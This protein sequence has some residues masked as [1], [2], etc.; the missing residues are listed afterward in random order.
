LGYWIIGRDTGLLGGIPNFKTQVSMWILK[1][2]ISDLA[3]FW[4]LDYLNR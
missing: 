4:F 3:L 2:K 1:K